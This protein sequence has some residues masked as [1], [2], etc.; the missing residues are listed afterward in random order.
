VNLLSHSSDADTAFVAETDTIINAEYNTSGSSQDSF[1]KAPTLDHAIKFLKLNPQTDE[2][3]CCSVCWALYPT[4]KESSDDFPQLCTN[5]PDVEGRPCGT[6]LRKW[7]ATGKGRWEPNRR[8]IMQDVFD[9]LARLYCRQDLEEYMDQSRTYTPAQDVSHFLESATVQTLLDLDGQTPFV[10][11]IGNCLVCLNQDGFNAF[12]EGGRTYKIGGLYLSCASLPPALQCRRENMCCIALTPGPFEPNGAQMIPIL[13]PLVDRFLELWYYGIYL[14]RTPKHRHGRHIRA[15]ICLFIGDYP[16]FSLTTGYPRHGHENF[17]PECGLPYSDIDD[18]HIECWRRRNW[19]DDKRNAIMWRD[20][21]SKKERLLVEQ[22]T[23]QMWSPLWRLPYWKGALMSPADRMHM[24]DLGLIPRHIRKIWGISRKI[25]DGDPLSH[26][27]YAD[28]PSQESMNIARSWVDEA[29][30][31]RFHELD[32][33]VLRALCREYGLQYG[34]HRGRKRMIKQLKNYVRLDPF[35]KDVSNRPCRHQE[36]VLQ[37]LLADMLMIVLILAPRPKLR[38]VLIFFSTEELFADINFS[39]D[40][41]KSRKGKRDRWLTVALLTPAIARDYYLHRSK[42]KIIAD[43]AQD[44]LVEFVRLTVLDHPPDI[45]SYNCVNLVALIQE[46]VSRPIKSRPLS[47]YLHLH[48][49]KRDNL[50]DAQGRIRSQVKQRAPTKTTATVLLGPIMLDAIETNIK[51][52]RL[53]SGV[54][55]PPT[56]LG[57]AGG[58]S[59]TA[60]EWRTLATITIPLTLLQKWGAKPPETVEYRRL[61]NFMHLV[62]AI[63]QT[64]RTSLSKRDISAYT[65]HIQKYLSGILEL[66]PGTSIS[67]Y[68]HRSAHF[69]RTMTLYGPTPAYN[70]GPFEQLNG[71]MKKIPHN[72]HGGAINSDFITTVAEFWLRGNG[73]HNVFQ[74]CTSSKPARSAGVTNAS[75]GDGQDT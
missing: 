41:P 62:A 63:R 53:P 72:N 22:T 16:A 67:P 46:A 27:N 29:E 15:A 47:R 1:P 2:F 66:Y 12:D 39:L 23:G 36:R 4:T 14:T 54:T 7:R 34:G 74:I 28:T 8:F 43:M 68:Q 40:V 57:T 10:R 58:G 11:G 59:Y 52:T 44:V 21:K 56:G 69:D 71:Q 70:T 3:V 75:A 33:G 65:E 45:A 31:G 19:E 6:A 24:F 13:D 49:R 73:I 17:C 18:I 38:Q 64:M 26:W 25:P 35:R 20:A 60:A 42:T 50:V 30:L 9:W 32:D 61:Q 55:R 37:T 48:Q 51:Q 5:I